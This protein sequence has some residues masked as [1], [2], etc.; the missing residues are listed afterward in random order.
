MDE[1][2]LRLGLSLAIGLL[3]GL[4]RGWR[5]REAPEGSRAAGIRTY[6]ISGLYGGLL[7]VLS[8]EL[9]APIVFPAGLLA[10][11]AIFGWYHWQEA[12][13]RDSN[14]VTSVVA[15]L[16]V[17][18]LGGL[19]VTGDYRAAAA[20]GA[21]L[22]GMLGGRGMLHG[23]L[24]HLNWAELRSALLLAAMTAIVLPILP[25]RT[26]DPWAGVNLFEIWL[27]TVMTAAI[28]FVGYLGVRLLG[29]GRGLLFSSLAGA[30]VSSTAV[31]VALSRQA[32]DRSL[33][34]RPLAGGT[35]LAAMISILRVLVL[36]ALVKP[37]ILVQ[38]VIPALCAAAV[39]GAAGLMQYVKF[40]PSSFKGTAHGNPFDL[41]P[42]LVFA[43]S[44]LAV[45]A[46]S[47][48]L[49]SYFGA[50]SVIFTSAFSGFV[51][52]DVATLSA[53]RLAGGTVS[54]AIAGIAVLAAIA[55][56]AI[57]HVAI[58]ITSGRKGYFVPVL[59]A[60]LIAA[61]AGLAGFWF[62]PLV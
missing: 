10:F 1:L 16:V 53:A 40:E 39:F 41:M 26:I 23:M 49:T 17:V 5:E 18:S 37:G 29:P 56:N 7:A 60:N 2:I 12:V 6:G 9:H 33:P 38:I 59:L 20:G 8:G 45:A 28:S 31:T 36:V 47:A 34:V 21:A 15:G 11:A 48:A 50:I 3:V 44:F 32:T 57:T 51:D 52:V 25:N 43:G 61:I 58:A 19:A 14:S 24:R 4:E 46:I 13:K 27:F 62:N 22:A 55:A 42:L 30:V 35:S 54:F